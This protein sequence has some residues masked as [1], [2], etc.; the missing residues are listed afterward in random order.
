M[1]EPATPFRSAEF[2]LLHEALSGAA[3]WV[4]EWH[5]ESDVLVEIGGSL[6]MLGLPPPASG[7]TQADWDRLIHPDDFGRG[8]DLYQRHARGE[9]AVYEYTYRVHDA[10]GRWRWMQERGRIVER[11]A[12]GRPLRMVGTQTDVHARV[13]A[14]QRGREAEHQLVTLA[15]QVPGLMFQ[16]RLDAQGQ[17]RVE[18]I[19][20][21]LAGWF[22][23]PD[24]WLDRLEPDD[25]AH[26]IQTLLSSAD[27][28]RDWRCECRVR[29]PE[30]RWRWLL[31]HASPE[32]AVDGS[33]VWSG[34]AEDVS[35]HR[36]LQRARQDTAVLAAASRTQSELLSRMSH[37][38]RT[39]MNAVLGFAQLM[40]ID[41]IEPPGPVQRQRLA[42]IRKAGEH[43]VSLIGSVLELSRIESGVLGLVPQT[44]ELRDEAVKAL[45]LMQPAADR[46]GVELRLRPGEPLRCQADAERLRQVLLQ[47]LGNAVGHNR[48]GGRV[49]VDLMALADGGQGVPAAV[50][51]VR[52]NG[53]GMAAAQL[54]AVRDPFAAV[55]VADRGSDTPRRGMGL[56]IAQALLALMGGRL[57]L[58][59]EPGAGCEATVVLPV[60]AG[61]ADE[62]ADSAAAALP[63]LQS[64]T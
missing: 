1:S 23:S 28:L 5:I 32:R 10:G 53:P 59:S 13:E 3:T 49:T 43:L 20:G 55:A 18:R 33:T 29:G 42:A 21:R 60:D 16:I 41:A 45:A 46:A 63:W 54:A 12:Q 39:P 44:L 52:D 14:E 7:W 56:P 8:E 30:G 22:R 40:E 24:D 19:S 37:E 50:L 4:W 61:L 38:L 11:D 35:V 15:G 51:R 31:A 6:E 2:A 27:T 62:A 9:L 17:T 47:L 25:Q 36:E 34:Y 58:S 48:R 57:F 26:L 64:I